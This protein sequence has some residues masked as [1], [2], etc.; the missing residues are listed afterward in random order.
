MVNETSDSQYPT[1]LEYVKIGERL[2][3]DDLR[4]FAFEAYKLAHSDCW[5][6]V[7]ATAVLMNLTLDW[8]NER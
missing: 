1:Q 6:G 2:A 8:W 7:K 5:P 3:P 4:W